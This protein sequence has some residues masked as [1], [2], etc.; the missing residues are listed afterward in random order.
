MIPIREFTPDHFQYW[1]TPEGDRPVS[2]SIGSPTERAKGIEPAT[3]LRTP[4]RSDK[5][6]GQSV[7]RLGFVLTDADVEQVRAG[8]EVW[9]SMWGVVPM[10]MV[11]VRQVPSLLDLVVSEFCPS[12]FEGACRERDAVEAETHCGHWY[13]DEG[14]CACGT[15]E[16][17]LKVFG[18]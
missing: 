10:H 8:T 17:N 6:F 4:P 16:P 7:Y 9:V 1:T 13:E 11:E 12:K 5:D 2:M 18:D 15:K 3:A 14:C